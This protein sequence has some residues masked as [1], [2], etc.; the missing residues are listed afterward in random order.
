[1][2]W[3]AEKQPYSFSG[4]AAYFLRLGT[5]GFG[6]PIALTGAMQRDLV[7]DRA[8]ITE[9]EYKE[10]L[11]LAQL[12]PGPLAAQLSIYIGW[13][14]G[15]IPGAS[16]IGLAFVLP[17]F[18]MVLVLAWFY[19]KYQGLEW[20]Q[21]AFYGIGAFVIAIIANS[22]N[23][24]VRKTLKADYFLWALFFLSAVITAVTEKEIV[25]VFLFSGLLALFVKAP[26]KFGGRAG[27]LSLAPLWW[28]GGLT[29]QQE[30]GIIREIFLYFAKAGS[31]V[32]GSGLAIVPF[33]HGGVVQEHHWLTERQFLDAVAVAMVTPGP[34]VITVA[35]I[36]ALIAG[37][38]GASAAALGVFFPCFLFVVVP[39]P[40]YKR[41]AGNPQVKAVVD[42]VT[43]SAVGALTGAVWVLG[44]RA[45][46]DLPTALIFAVGLLVVIRFKK[47]PE[48]FLI[49]GAGLAGLMLR[50]F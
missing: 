35:F 16:V 8:W 31:V 13:L 50:F 24:L 23:K 27:A 7:D 41:F 20:L 36:G 28:L 33:L 32:F 39:A 40:F 4:L 47:I 3:V 19:V 21:A 46:V 6:G 1:V 2:D 11:A 18:L 9:P 17:S 22:V 14:K 45:I 43:A 12:A 49:L 5:L 44:K 34:V 48:P 10:G 29:G 30:P 42:G 37:L 38:A 25:W 15:G 26:P